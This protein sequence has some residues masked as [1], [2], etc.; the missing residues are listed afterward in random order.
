MILI[1]DDEP[2]LGASLAKMLRFSGLEAEAVTSGGEALALL[3]VHTPRL[4]IL[5]L[6]MPLLGGLVL[7]KSI[8]SDPV[9]KA[10][11]I[12]VYTSDFSLSSQNGALDAGAQDYIVKGTIGWDAL[13]TRVR[14]LLA[15]RP[16][17]R[18]TQ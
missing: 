4:I 1:V 12:L 9:F 5:D 8:R 3:S 16:P 10:V 18:I 15:D 14:E 11:P 17:L 13:L 6:Q 7:L 2:E